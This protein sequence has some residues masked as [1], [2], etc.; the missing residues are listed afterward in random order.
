MTPAAVH[1]LFDTLAWISAALAGWLVSRGDRFSFPV[2]PA[3][4]QSYFAALV[5]GSA[6]G[7]YLF[8]TLNLWASGQEGI[9]RS[10]EGAIFGAVFSVELYKRA[11]GFS[12]RTGARFAAPLAV[13][14][15]VGRIGCFLAGLEDFTYGTPST[16][17]W[18]HDFGDGIPRHPV[19]LYESLAM[20]AFLLAYLAL[21]LRGSRF[22]V[23]NGLY[24]AIGFYAAQR[25]AWEFIKPYGSVVGPLGVFHLLSLAL[26]IY[27]VAMLATGQGAKRERTLPA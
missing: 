12:A 20:A 8:G 21:A 16:L 26:F 27:A 4:R 22:A 24:L 19:Q 15:A 23:A 5:F 6:M 17:P 11:T 2:E 9:A 13:G 14:V 25:F 7:A 10:I 3:R 18:A 1:T